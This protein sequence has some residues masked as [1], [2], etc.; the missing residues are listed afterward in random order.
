MAVGTKTGPSFATPKH[1]TPIQFLRRPTPLA[2][3]KTSDYIYIKTSQQKGVILN[4]HDDLYTVRVAQIRTD[5]LMAYE[6]LDFTEAEL[7]TPT[8]AIRR[9]VDEKVTFQKFANE[10]MKSVAPPDPSQLVN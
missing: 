2:K 1:P 8:E 10:A 4:C 6:N 3:Y 9:E 7:E 5:G